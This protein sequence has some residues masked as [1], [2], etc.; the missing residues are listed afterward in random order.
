MFKQ[1]LPLCLFLAPV[2]TRAQDVVNKPVAKQA[3]PFSLTRGVMLSFG[4]ASTFLNSD[5]FDLWATQH[6]A[7]KVNYPLN[8]NGSLILLINKVD[9]GVQVSGTGKLTLANFLGGYQVYNK[10]RYTSLAEFSLGTLRTDYKAV[11]PPGFSLVDENSGAKNYL[12]GKSFLLGLTT[13]HV[14]TFVNK[15][16]YDIA[17]IGVFGTVNYRLGDIR[18]KYG[19]DEKRYDDDGSSYNH[20][21]GQRVYDVPAYGRVLLSVGVYVGVGGPLT[22]S[23]PRMLG[24]QDR[25]G[26]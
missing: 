20:F 13:R 18:W 24:R 8:F 16:G 5:K 14:F 1:F 6:G 22:R 12:R 3:R 19:Y 7:S 4:T 9:F 2:L 23:I 10:G 25:G 17:H 15:N 26:N 11:V 21:T